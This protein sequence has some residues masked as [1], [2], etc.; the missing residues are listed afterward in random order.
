[1]LFKLHRKLKSYILIE[2][3]NEFYIIPHI[4]KIK[5]NKPLIIGISIY[6]LCFKT[7][8]YLRKWGK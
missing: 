8:I 6:A 1:M 2:L 3:K 7:S 5:S 4:E